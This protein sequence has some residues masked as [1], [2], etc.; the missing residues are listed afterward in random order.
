M[1]TLNSIITLEDLPSAIDLLGKVF[2]MVM[3]WLHILP[4]YKESLRE[5]KVN[6]L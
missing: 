4:N 2:E 6:H 5:V 1:L 3:C